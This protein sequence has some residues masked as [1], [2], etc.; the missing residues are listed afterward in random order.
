[1]KNMKL[2][3]GSFAIAKLQAKRRSL[4]AIIAIIAVIGFSFASCKGADPTEAKYVST[5]GTNTYELVISAA[6]AVYTPKDGDNYVLTINPGNKISKGTVAVS[7]GSFSLTPNGSTEAFTITIT[8]G[9]MTAISGNIADLGI[10]V[11]ATLTPSNSGN[12][13]NA[14]LSGTWLEKDASY[15]DASILKFNNGNWEVSF[16]GS[17][18][19]KGTYTTKDSKLTLTLTHLGKLTKA[20]YLALLAKEDAELAKQAA[21]LLTPLSASYSIN[22]NILTLSFDD[23]EKALYWG[24]GDTYTRQ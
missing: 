5:D 21:E 13:N 17:V 6:K 9:N 22:G 15:R 8:G 24:L 12:N 14:A 1:M 3:L 18:A 11:S 19:S 2:N 23:Y 7:G 4:L 16:K 20:E 10:N